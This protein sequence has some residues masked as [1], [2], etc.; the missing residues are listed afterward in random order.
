MTKFELAEKF[1]ATVKNQELA[2]QLERMLDS[3][4]SLEDIIKEYIAWQE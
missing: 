1:I 4:Y 3:G 2:Y